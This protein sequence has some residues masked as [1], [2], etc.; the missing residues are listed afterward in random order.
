MRLTSVRLR[1]IASMLR[2]VFALVCLWN[3]AT[4]SKSS[5]VV[6]SISGVSDDVQSLRVR[7]FTST[8]AGH[9]QILE[10]NTTKLVIDL[11]DNAEGPMT[12]VVTGRDKDTCNLSRAEQ[13]VDLSTS[14][15]SYPV[16]D[17]SL[18]PLTGNRT[19]TL[20]IYLDGP[21]GS[22][23]VEENGKVCSE[24][25][26]RDCDIDFVQGGAASL[27][28]KATT[29][30]YMT[31]TGGCLKVQT[32]TTTVD[33]GQEVNTATSAFVNT[34]AGWIW[35][36]PLPQGADLKALWG[37]KSDDIW[38]GGDGGILLHWD[39]RTWTSFRTTEQSDINA[40]WGNGTGAVWAIDNS[41]NI[42]R[43]N[44]NCV[45]GAPCW[46]RVHTT[47]GVSLLGIA[48]TSATDVWVVGSAGNIVHWD[49]Q[50][51]SSISAAASLASCAN[52]TTDFLSILANGDE[53]LVGGNSGR[54]LKIKSGLPS[55]CVSAGFTENIVSIWGTNT[56]NFWLL[57]NKGTIQACVDGGTCSQSR[58]ASSIINTSESWYKILGQG[59]S[60]IYAIGQ[61]SSVPPAEFTTA[62]LMIHWDGVRWAQINQI[63][64]LPLRALYDVSASKLWAV[65]S[66]GV[67]SFLDG[68]SWREFSYGTVSKLTA[69]STNLKSGQYGIWGAA[70]NDIWSVGS[71]GLIMHWDGLLWQE[72]TGYRT[73]KIKLLSLSGSGAN[74]IWAVG[75][76]DWPETNLSA[77]LHWNGM[78]WEN[79]AAKQTPPIS[80]NYFRSVYVNNRDNV[81]AVGVTGGGAAFSANWNGSKW[82][83]SQDYVDSQG[84]LDVIADNNGAWIVTSHRTENVI[85]FQNSIDSTNLGK[86]TIPTTSKLFSI[87]GFSIGGYISVGGAGL[88]CKISNGICD[89][90][91]SKSNDPS[92]PWFNRIR[93]NGLSD[94]VAISSNPSTVFR[95]SNGNW[96]RLSIGIKTPVYDIWAATP[97][98]LWVV[99]AGGAILRYQPK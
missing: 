48:G 6:I 45:S 94:F 62:P 58:P 69:D 53:A 15:L 96:S 19:C 83:L 47:N 50:Q 82:K 30:R 4:C 8:Q 11:P 27:V 32:C 41:G 35:Q 63:P 7:A 73:P 92:P 79:T 18:A 56:T 70:T 54:L 3:L 84:H 33:R 39:G 67:I 74:D 61:T 46:S 60:S 40:I 43:T 99:G 91:E 97:D 42:H 29:G 51:W 68:S 38:A 26:P 85:L 25:S 31:F 20:G 80:G 49:G 17:I 90:S 5:S 52:A 98:D 14:R 93:T 9:P 75:D 95:R 28:G 76:N 77:I 12:V 1:G 16:L 22:V 66:A 86:I 89:L 87:S 78:T 65:G 10:R 23:K 2:G 36:D 13:V 37:S 64:N 81:W 24:Q 57:G 21:G 44:G 88:I 72:Q 59:G 55:A 34:G 71:F